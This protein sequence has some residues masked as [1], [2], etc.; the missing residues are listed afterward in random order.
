MER[1]SLREQGSSRWRWRDRTE[2]WQAGRN[3]SLP[4]SATTCG[5]QKIPASRQ[6]PA[7]YNRMLVPEKRLGRDREFSPNYGT[8]LFHC[9]S[10]KYVSQRSQNDADQNQGYCFQLES[11]SL[12]HVVPLSSAP[13]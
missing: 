4:R 3:Y 13:E 12:R 10:E 7:R 11:A 6:C 1:S 5:R 2:M 8:Q 9:L